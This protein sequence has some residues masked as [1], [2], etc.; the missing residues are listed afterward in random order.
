MKLFWAILC[1][2]RFWLSLVGIKCSHNSAQGLSI[3]NQDAAHIVPQEKLLIFPPIQAGEK[4]TRELNSD[5]RAAT[6]A[7]FS[8]TRQTRRQ[9]GIIEESADFA[10]AHGV[11]AQRIAYHC[12]CTPYYGFYEIFL[13]V[14]RQSSSLLLDRSGLKPIVSRVETLQLYGC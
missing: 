14:L 2:E 11:R 10:S 5:L 9:V 8:L 7:E 13:F 3:Q 1:L 6:A 4:K 12:E